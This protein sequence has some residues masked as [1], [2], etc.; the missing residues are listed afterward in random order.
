MCSN[1]PFLKKGA[2]HLIYM[3]IAKAQICCVLRLV[4]DGA[5]VMII[6]ENLMFIAKP[7]FLMPMNI[8]LEEEAQAPILS[9]TEVAPLGLK[10][11]ISKKQYHLAR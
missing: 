3:Y 7:R 10:G 8:V 4:W 9:E 1:R 11:A 2:H 6:A 5:A